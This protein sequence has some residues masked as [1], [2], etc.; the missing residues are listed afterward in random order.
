[1]RIAGIGLHQIVMLRFPLC[2]VHLLKY[3]EAPTA[4]FSG[5]VAGDWYLSY[6]EDSLK[7][8]GSPFAFFSSNSYNYAERLTCYAY[9]CT[10]IVHASTQEL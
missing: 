7:Y 4:N 3:A 5:L 10:P 2:H 9:M 1:M 6:G 8:V